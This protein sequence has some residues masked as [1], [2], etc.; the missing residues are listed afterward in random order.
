MWLKFKLNRALHPLRI[1]LPY[2]GH[3]PNWST[4]RRVRCCLYSQRLKVGRAAQRP[5]GHPSA[6]LDF[7]L[8]LY[9]LISCW[10]LK[11]WTATKGW[12]QDTNTIVANIP[13]YVLAF[14]LRDSRLI[15]GLDWFGSVDLR[16]LLGV[17]IQLRVQYT[18]YNIQV[19]WGNDGTCCCWWLYLNGSILKNM[20]VNSLAFCNDFSIDVARF[21][22]VMFGP[23]KSLIQGA[24]TH[25]AL[26]SIWLRRGFVGLVSPHF[27]R[28]WLYQGIA[29][30][31][32]KR[33][34][35]PRKS[36]DDVQPEHGCKNCRK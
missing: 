24:V 8:V 15:E 17:H 30:W 25:M 35:S 18:V 9:G 36:K 11:R 26:H 16:G 29:K 32:Q 13:I 10:A 4:H 20:V 2:P 21:M 7:A 6:W 19:W 33:F 14:F 12:T 22:T 5:E 31:S 23:C 28:H 1:G 27:K 34:T 3:T